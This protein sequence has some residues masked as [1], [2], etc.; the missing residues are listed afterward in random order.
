MGNHRLSPADARRVAVRAQLL[1]SPRPTDLMDVLRHLTSVQLDPTAAIAPSADLVLWSRVGSA[2]DPRSLREALE[3]QRVVELSGVLRPMADLPL[4]RAE[5]AQWG[6]PEAAGW[7][8]ARAAWVA[9]NRACRLDVLER[10]RADGPLLSRELPDTCVRPWRSTGW[11]H[12]KNMTQM[13]ELLALMGVVAIAGRGGA[14]G[15]PG[16]ERL[17]DLAERVY[18]DEPAVPLDE[19]LRRRGT[20]RLAALG[21]ARANGAAQQVEPVDVGAAGEEAVVDGVRGTWRVDPILLDTAVEGRVALLSPF[22]RLIHDRRRMSELF[23]F[24]YALEMFKPAAKRR[25]G[26]YALPVLVGDELVG[27]LDA[28][29]DRAAGALRVTALHLDRELTPGDLDAVEEQIDDLARWLELEV[30]RER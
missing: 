7:Q 11:T 8:R 25:W 2:Y 29:A 9:D 20:R 24:D 27:K 28:S 6:G 5:M 12:H 10:L 18:P 21:I 13:L 3:E 15:G 17:W 19:A 26:F 30:V 14:G 1:A 16:R 23:G 4:F 22:D